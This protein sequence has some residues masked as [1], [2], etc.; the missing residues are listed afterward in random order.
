MVIYMGKKTFEFGIKINGKEFEIKAYGLDGAHEISVLQS[1]LQATK[2]LQKG[3][4][5]LRP[6]QYYD[7]SN[8][9]YRVK[10]IGFSNRIEIEGY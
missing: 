6:Y 8:A 2:K 1:A 5:V 9:G 7:C 4:T 3:V 10:N